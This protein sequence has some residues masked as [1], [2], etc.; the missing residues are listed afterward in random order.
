MFDLDDSESGA[1][2]AGSP[3]VS[4][5]G[6][7]LSEE[8]EE[9]AVFERKA[10]QKK[11]KRSVMLCVGAASLF[12]ETAIVG[13]ATLNAAAE[14]AKKQTSEVTEVTEVTAAE[15]AEEEK[16]KNTGAKPKRSSLKAS[17]KY[18]GEGKRQRIPSSAR[19]EGIEVNGL[20]DIMEHRD[21]LVE[22]YEAAPLQNKLMFTKVDETVRRVQSLPLRRVSTMRKEKDRGKKKVGSVHFFAEDE[23][24][25]KN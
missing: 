4:G 11:G 10:T 1:T 14:E 3:P 24:E 9:C 20:E 2:A 16:F 7:S 8:S 21:S 22:D 5:S 6:S 23:D 13:V 17:S 12:T 18:D 19:I 15:L 25:G